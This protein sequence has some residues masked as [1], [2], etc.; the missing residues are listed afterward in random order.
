MT[1]GNTEVKEITI[2]TKDGDL[3]ATVT[4]EN[5]VRHDDYVVTLNKTA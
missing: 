3:V 1:T 2:A 5:F 4:D